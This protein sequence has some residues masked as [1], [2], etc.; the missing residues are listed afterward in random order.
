MRTWAYNTIIPNNIEDLVA[1]RNF[2]KTF[3]TLHNFPVLIDTNFIVDSTNGNGLGIRSLKGPGIQNVFMN[4]SAPLTGSG[5]PNPLPGYAIIF[6]QDNYSRYFG[7]FSGFASPVTGSPMATGLVVGTP[8]IIAS[9][10]A[11]TLAQFHTAGLPMGIVPAVGVSFIAAATSIAGGATVIAVGSSGI[12]SIEIVGNPQLSLSFNGS[13]RPG[14]GPYL[15]VKF[16]TD[17]AVTAPANGS[18]CGLS[19]YLS[20]SSINVQGE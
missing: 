9:L 2:T 16:L 14:Q 5:N 10:G 4:T 7:G 18:T 6:L 11:S 12:D 3:Y 15:I 1:N 19:F 13:P 8:Y 17:G 20:N